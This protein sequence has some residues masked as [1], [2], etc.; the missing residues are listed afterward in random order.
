VLNEFDLY[1][2]SFDFFID[3]KLTMFNSKDIW[4][5]RICVE[6]TSWPE[7]D[8]VLIQQWIK[9]LDGED[10]L[11]NLGNFRKNFSIIPRFLIFP[12]ISSP[13]IVVATV[14]IEGEIERE[15]L[16]VSVNQI[17]NTIKD[18]SG[19]PLWIGEKGLYFGSSMLE[20]V[21]S[22]TDTPWPGDIDY[23]LFQQNNPRPYVILEM[24]KHTLNS[25]IQTQKLSNYYPSQDRK[26]YD[27]L[28]LFAHYF[29]TEVP[30]LNIYYPTNPKVTEIKV[31][32]IMG[33]QNRLQSGQSITIT[34][35]KNDND[36]PRF[37]N[38]LMSCIKILKN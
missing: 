4:I 8:P 27:R 35:P 26:K 10:L 7:D 15:V 18:R 29:S 19:G 11:N 25:E 6:G 31:E 38:E 5:K 37:L 34:L 28:S 3:W 1:S 17:K 2:L 12:D 13:E 20:C 9:E 36:R 30:I 14:S 33:Q 22:K 24:K 16:T 21:L 23:I 32:R